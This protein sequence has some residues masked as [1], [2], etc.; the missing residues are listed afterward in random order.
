MPAGSDD[1]RRGRRD[2]FE[3]VTVSLRQIV[4][5]HLYAAAGRVIANGSHAGCASVVASYAA[6]IE[7]G[8]HPVLPIGT[9]QSL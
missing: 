6:A 3:R 1:Y 5:A 2:E 4:A 8:R 9:F 7:D